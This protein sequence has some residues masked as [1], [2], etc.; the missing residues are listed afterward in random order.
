MSILSAMYVYVSYVY[1]PWRSE[2]G[3]RSPGT[4]LTD[5]FELLHGWWERNSGPLQAQAFLITELTF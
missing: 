2:E 3:L 1:C 5:S 4:G